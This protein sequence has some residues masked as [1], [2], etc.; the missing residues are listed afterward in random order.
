MVTLMMVDGK[1]MG[2]GVMAMGR[3]ECRVVEGPR[4]DLM[5]EA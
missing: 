2:H 3:G 4:V 5:V 1:A